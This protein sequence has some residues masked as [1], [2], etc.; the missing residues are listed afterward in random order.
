MPEALGK[1]IKHIAII[2]DGNG[3][4]AKQRGLPRSEGHKEGAK[5]IEKVLKAAN[6]FGIEYITLYAFSTENWKRAKDEVSGLM[7]LLK[8]FLE[9]NLS[10]F[11]KNETRLRVIG[12]IDDIPYI[13]RTV[14]KKVIRDTSHYTRRQLILAL[15]YGG[16]AEIIDAVKKMANGVKNK[17]L[18]P[19][20]IDEKLFSKYLYAP[21]IPDPELMIR[22]GGEMRISN[23]LLWQL[24]YSELWIT[25]VLWPD[26]GEKDFEEAINSYYKRERR[27]GGV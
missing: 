15:S 22:T 11:K 3:R 14:L 8:E 16:R 9:V 4:W 1:K 18:N 19:E 17:G 10:V 24:S 2:M 27:Y 7:S 23:F 20:D 13:T 6:F 21:D 12:R 25:D 26:F 5:T